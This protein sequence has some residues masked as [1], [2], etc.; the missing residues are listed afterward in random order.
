M[1]GENF[2]CAA[3]GGCFEKS[4]PDGEAAEEYQ[5]LFQPHPG[6]D[7]L[8]LVCDDCWKKLMGQVVVEAPWL[9]R[10]LP[11]AIED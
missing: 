4:R 11:G 1:T 8:D 9:L 10:K 3:C 7:E 2:H 6:D 5:S